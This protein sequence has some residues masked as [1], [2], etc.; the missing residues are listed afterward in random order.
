MKEKDLTIEVEDSQCKHGLDNHCFPRTYDIEIVSNYK[1]MHSHAGYYIGRD[2]V[3]LEGQIL[4]YDRLS[5]YFDDR[6]HAIN[7]MAKHTTKGYLD[8]DYI[9]AHRYNFGLDYLEPKRL[10]T[11]ILNVE[12]DKH[13]VPD[14]IKSEVI[15]HKLTT[16]KTIDGQILIPEE[17]L[18]GTDNLL[19]EMIDT[20]E[21]INEKGEE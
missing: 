12:K 13:K 7:Y 18:K 19:N 10:P 14:N 17:L 15:D 21:A 16:T 6:N 4:P 11:H 8:I 20:Q 1:I 2:S 3:D 5:V 9:K